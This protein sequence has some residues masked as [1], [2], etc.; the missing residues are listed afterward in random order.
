[1][2]SEGGF[3]SYLSKNRKRFG[4]SISTVVVVDSSFLFTQIDTLKSD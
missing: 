4:S 3:V 1:M 2:N